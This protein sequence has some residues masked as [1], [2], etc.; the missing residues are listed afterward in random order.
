MIIRAL[1]LGSMLACAGCQSSGTAGATA[2]SSFGERGTLSADFSTVVFDFERGSDASFYLTDVD[3]DAL[4]RGNVD[5]GQVLHVE[6]LWTP[7]AGRT[8]MDD[9]ATNVTLRHVVI[10]DGEVGVYIG[11]GFA[12]VGGDLLGDEASLSIRASTMRLQESTPGFADALGVASIRG[13]LRAARDASEARQ[14]H[15]G[16][17]R[18]VSRALGG[19]HW[20]LHAPGLPHG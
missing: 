18:L 3:P 7:K 19:A 6:L 11:T 9:S 14:I 13:T 16:A 20:V 12:R 5:A 8:P 10:V 4:A 1:L 2:L 15:R 17:S